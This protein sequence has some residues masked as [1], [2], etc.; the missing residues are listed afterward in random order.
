[1]RLI[2]CKNTFLPFLVKIIIHLLVRLVLF[3]DEYILHEGEYN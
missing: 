2:N 3:D 1:M